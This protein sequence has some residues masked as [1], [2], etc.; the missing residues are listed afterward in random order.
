M[1]LLCNK[2]N[3]YFYQL[4]KNMKENLFKEHIG[5]KIIKEH[6]K[7]YLLISHQIKY[8]QTSI[9]INSICLNI[10]FINNFQV[11]Y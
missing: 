3:I 8:K 10:N 5:W 1:G 4:H 11:A 7:R 9:D 2:L 6:K